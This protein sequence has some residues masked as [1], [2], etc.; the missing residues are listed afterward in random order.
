MILICYNQTC[1][2]WQEIKLYSFVEVYNMWGV[3]L[4]QHL[5]FPVSSLGLWAPNVR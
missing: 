5:S 4:I 3:H 1:G 2:L